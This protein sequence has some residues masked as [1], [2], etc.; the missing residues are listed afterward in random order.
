[1]PVIFI[2]Y[3][4]SDSQDVTGR[5]YDRLV[6]RFTPRQ[7]FKDVDNI[8]LGVSF[9]LHLQQMLSKAG[10]VLVIIGPTWVTATDDRGRRRLDDP[11]DFVRLEVETALRAGIPVIPVLVSNAV[12]PAAGDLPRSLLGLVARNGM[13]IRPDPDFNNDIGRLFSGLERLE[14]LLQAQPANPAAPPAAVAVP[15]PEKQTLGRTPNPSPEAEASRK[16]A[17]AA[18]A[19]VKR[20]SRGGT[21]TVAVPATAPRSRK[22][23][24]KAWLFGILAV[25]LLLAGAASWLLGVPAAWWGGT[26]PVPP[27]DSRSQAKTDLAEYRKQELLWKAPAYIQQAGPKRVVAWREAAEQGSP[28]GQ[29]LFSRCLEDGAGSAKNDVESLAWLRKAVEQGLAPA[30][31]HLGH[32]HFGGKGV[33]ADPVEWLRWYRKAADQ[34]D[35]IAECALGDCYANG[36]GVAKD[37]AEAARW[38]RKAADQHYVWAEHNLGWAYYHGAGVAKDPAEGVRWLRKAAE[39]GLASAQ[40]SVGWFEETDKGAG[41]GAAEAVRWYRK[42]ADQ[43]LEVAQHNLG[44]CLFFG[45]G[46]DKDQAEAVR[47][48]RKSADQNYARA[49]ASLGHCYQHGEGVARDLTEAMRWYRLAAARGDADAQAALAALEKKETPK[50]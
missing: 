32:R 37:P 40:N 47:W 17:E 33:P 38:L 16:R 46:V 41:K 34:G 2:S 4:R 26:A 9:P 42:A 28:E 43:G 11:N 35:P 20:L 39:Q 7:V 24:W 48:F 31:T 23:P 44:L 36:W 19:T 8:P 18:P 45:R 10:A 27:P 22:K 5:I 12:M 15:P 25:Q 29:F 1:M 6:G 3:R 49:Q 13:A 21:V 14:N 30:Q 50:K